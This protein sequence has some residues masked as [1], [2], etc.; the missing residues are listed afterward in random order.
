MLISK[1]NKKGNPAKTI[2]T[3]FVL[4][5]VLIIMITFIYVATSFTKPNSLSDSGGV[6]AGDLFSKVVVVNIDGKI[7]K[8]TILEGLL[9]YQEKEA[10]EGGSGFDLNFERA[11]KEFMDKY[12]VDAKLPV[13]LSYSVESYSTE[14]GFEKRRV[15]VVKDKGGVSYAKGDA[16]RVQPFE[17]INEGIIFPSEENL[18]GT[19]SKVIVELK[20]LI[21]DDVYN[22]PGISLNVD[23]KDVDIYYYYGKCGGSK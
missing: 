7:D 6:S 23:N 22:L 13:C 16:E 20:E 21:K 8:V 12:N 4:I 18:L 1:M 14:K 11:L 3:F 5:A 17:V 19:N 10:K 15:L 9:K 2:S